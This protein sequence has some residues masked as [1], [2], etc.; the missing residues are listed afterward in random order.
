M[1]G[2]IRRALDA[3]TGRKAPEPKAADARIAAPARPRAEAR[4]AGDKAKSATAAVVARHPRLHKKP[5]QFDYW[6]LTVP[7]RERA[8]EAVLAIANQRYGV[9]DAPSLPFAYCKRE[10]NCHYVGIID[11]RRGQRRKNSERR[12]EI[13]FEPAKTDRR[14]KSGRRKGDGLKNNRHD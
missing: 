3:L 6:Q 12:E 1:S 10:C 2:I 5:E 13:R 14:Q 8:C 7:N 4:A 11:Q 9:D